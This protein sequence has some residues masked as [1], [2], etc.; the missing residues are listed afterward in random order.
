[1]KTEI[2]SQIRGSQLFLFI[3]IGILLLTNTNNNPN[4]IIQRIFKPIHIGEGGTFY[5]AGLLPLL[6]IYYSLKEIYK[7]NNLRLLSTT[8]RR[9]VV[10]LLLLSII[11]SFSE[12]GIKLFKSFFN[13]LNSIYCYRNNMNLSTKTIGDRNQVVCMMDL[14]NCSSK[15]REFYVK[16]D[17]PSDLKVLKESTLISR[18]TLLVFNAHEKR[19]FE[20]IFSDSSI[21]SGNVTFKISNFSFLLY[22]DS[23]EVKFCRPD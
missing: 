19:R 21:N 22:N 13:D 3:C 8:F 16:V 17:L 9:I 5:Y 11:P 1:M 12:S 14:E 7:L 15:S 4:P 23:E 18:D 20:V 6:L 2:H 10:L